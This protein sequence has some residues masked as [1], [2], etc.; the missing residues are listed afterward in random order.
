MESER[1]ETLGWKAGDSFDVS[2][3]KFHVLVF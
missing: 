1:V 3:S 2:E